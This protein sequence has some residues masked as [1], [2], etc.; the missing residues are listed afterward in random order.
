MR[1]KSIRLKNL[2]SLKGEHTVRLDREPLA[3]SG[4]FAITGPTGAG[5]STLLDAITLALYGKAARYGNDANPEDMMSRHCGECEAEVEFE[6]KRGGGKES[7]RAVWKRHRAGGRPDGKLQQPQRH[8]YDAAGTALAQQVREAEATIEELL[9]LNYERFLR[10]ALLAQG[11]FAKFLKSNDNDRA[12][13]LEKLTGTEIY[14]EIGRLAYDEADKRS[15][16]IDEQQKALDLIDVLAPEDRKALDDGITKGDEQ[17]DLLKEMVSQGEDVIGKIKKLEEAKAKE[18]SSLQVLE[19]LEHER[20]E[21]EE[22]LKRLDLHAKTKAYAKPLADLESAHEVFESCQEENSSAEVDVKETKDNL[23][24]AIFVLRSA[25]QCELTDTKRIK[26]RAEVGVKSLTKE[27]ESIEKWLTENTKDGNLSRD[28]GTVSTMIGNL[29]SERRVLADRWSNWRKAASSLLP[30]EAL[31]TTPL[32]LEAT[33]KGFLK[34]ANQSL[35]GIHEK[36]AQSKDQL[37]K[38]LEA[39]DEAKLREGLAEHRKHL[40]KGEECPLCGALDHPY[41][42][43]AMKGNST[44]TLSEAVRNLRELQDDLKRNKQRLEDGIKKL[45]SDV[46]DVTR[47]LSDLSK[48][49]KAAGQI[50]T[51]LGLEIPMPNKERQLQES[52]QEKANAYTTKNDEKATMANKLREEQTLL[53]GAEKT[54]KDLNKRLDLSPNLPAGVDYEEMDPEDLPTVEDAEEQYQEASRGFTKA[55]TLFKGTSNAFKT[56]SDK[57]SKAK[58]ALL[59]KIMGSPFATVDALREAVMDEDDAEKIEG[60]RTSLNEKKTG[61]ETLLKDARKTMAELRKQKTLEGNEAVSFKTDHDS[62]KKTRDDLIENLAT[63]KARRKT[64]DANKVRL[65]TQQKQLQQMRAELAVWTRLREMIGSADGSKFRKFA[66][67][68]S[69][70]ILTHHANRHLGKLSDRYRISRNTESSLSLQ[71]EDLHQAGVRRPMASLS[72]GE[73]FLVSLALALGLSDLA[74]RSIQID[75]LFIDEGFGSLDPD[76][77]E[78]AIDALE[79]L[80][81]NN[82]TVGIISHVGLLKER[83]GTQ[84]IVEKKAGGISA[85]RVHPPA[86]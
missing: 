29:I 54:L 47:A 83:I 44:G 39:L 13:L 56:A 74:G 60:L 15:T 4:I 46:T 24:A 63:L 76:T 20:K 40:K 14:S 77:L 64:D 85:L 79:G 17:L 27:K 9:G 84:I 26:D 53:D 52:L 28:I 50:L 58:E 22:E 67:S 82:K 10:S 31:E 36:I 3:G 55:D 69:L 7:Y 62:K 5:K 78:V 38:Q 6:V 30:K 72:G 61:A 25:I 57:F 32:D 66:Q 48:A 37:D 86:A 1:I 59:E 34:S 23:H 41:S 35:E 42:G 68:I 33:M 51:P 2:N 12:E 11:E 21:A 45:T 65:A 18:A 19:K 70:D 71:I 75:S 80:R 73:S 81:Q 8:I 43:K 16:V 49:E